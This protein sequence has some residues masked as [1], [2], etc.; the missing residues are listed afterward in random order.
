MEKYIADLANAPLQRFADWPNREIPSVCAGVYTVHDRHR[1]IYVGMAGA[2]LNE[3]AIE[4]KRAAGKRSGLFDR[5]NSHASGYRSGD[6]FNIYIGDLY[7]LSTLSPDDV[8][9]ISAGIVSFDAFIKAFI[10]AELSYRY[11]ITPNTSVREL[12]THIQIDGIDGER[13]AINGKH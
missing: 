6:R 3:S 9:G 11:V 8:A 12:E 4:Q 2:G 7:V 5:L 13:P 10:R 1:F